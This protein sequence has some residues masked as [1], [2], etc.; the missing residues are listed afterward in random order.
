[1]VGGVKHIEEKGLTAPT[2]AEG[3]NILLD[4]VTVEAS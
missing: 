4:G 2:L 1:M 3:L